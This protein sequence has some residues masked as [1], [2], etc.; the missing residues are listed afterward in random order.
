[1][2]EGNHVMESTMVVDDLVLDASLGSLVRNLQH[3]FGYTNQDLANRAQISLTTVHNLRNYGFVHGTPLPSPTVIKLVAQVFSIDPLRLWEATGYVDD[4][5]ISDLSHSVG[6]RFHHLNS[7]ARELVLSFL[8]VVESADEGVVQQDEYSS[9]G[10]LIRGIQE[11]RGWTNADM[12]R[13][14]GLSMST[15]QALRTL[16]VGE[17]NMP[18]IHVLASVARSLGVS[19]RRVLQLA[20]YIRNQ[21]LSVLA[22]SIGNRVVALDEDVRAVFIR[23][24]EIISSI[25]LSE[26]MRLKLD[27]CED[28]G[29]SCLVVK[30]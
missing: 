15:I 24:L 1:M 14:C 28:G 19:T 26:G 13:M 4:V 20:G 27:V 2:L 21:D 25:S 7:S 5:Q 3:E 23:M 6:V 8:S 22:E 9:L 11:S 12:A 17:V 10:E 16:E 29:F 30:G 18:S